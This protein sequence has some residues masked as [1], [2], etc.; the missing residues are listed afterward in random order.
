MKK[1]VVEEMGSYMQF[2]I[3]R[4]MKIRKEKNWKEVVER[5]QQNVGKDLYKSRMKGKEIILTLKEE[6]IEQYLAD[7]IEEQAEKC[8]MH[9]R[10]NLLREA[11]GL[12]GRNFDE[13]IEII[14]NGGYQYVQFSNYW[15]D[16]SYL[17]PEREAEIDVEER[18]L[19][20]IEGKVYM[21][22]YDELFTYMR[23]AIIA[24]SQNPIRTALV[25]TMD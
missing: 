6:V 15:A 19:Y 8:T 3:A 2:G 7:F 11:S 12:K 25:L 9:I 21:E 18:I 4:R 10:A 24:S 14:D 17:D 16:V 13:M 23:N 1:G 22:H 5:V 20:L